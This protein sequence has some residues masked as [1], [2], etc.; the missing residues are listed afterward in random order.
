MS[1]ILLTQ[2]QLHQVNSHHFRLFVLL[3]YLVRIFKATIW[4][5]GYTI[6]SLFQA[7]A[8]CTM[9]NVLRAIVWFGVRKPHISS[10]GPQIWDNDLR[11]GFYGLLAE[12]TSLHCSP[13]M[14]SEC[15]SWK[16]GKDKKS[17]I[18]LLEEVAAHDTIPIFLPLFWLL[19][20]KSRLVITGWLLQFRYI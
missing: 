5:V 18:I 14:K 17:R 6:V 11:P 10:R 16:G 20:K 13:N 19:K 15:K 7:W 2:L 4:N 12:R 9:T 1:Q 8:P 3:E